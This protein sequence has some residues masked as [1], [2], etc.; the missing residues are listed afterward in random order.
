MPV[1][2]LGFSKG[3]TSAPRSPHPRMGKLEAP[4]Q[5]ISRL[6]GVLLLEIVAF[7]NSGWAESWKL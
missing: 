2:P 3:K 5:A 4:I 6:V 7:T 1:R